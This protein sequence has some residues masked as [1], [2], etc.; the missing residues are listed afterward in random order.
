MEYNITSKTRDGVL[1]SELTLTYEH[2]GK[3]S[4]WPSGPYT[5]YVRVYVPNASKLTAARVNTNNV[6]DEDVLKKITEVFDGN[7]K[8][9]AYQLKVEPTEIVKFTLS[10]DLPES[11]NI[12]KTGS[13]Y[14]LVWQK[15]PGTTDDA[16][17]F[18]FAPP[19]GI[20]VEAVSENLSKESESY[21]RR[22]FIDSDSFYSIKFK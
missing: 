8:Y 7:Y 1:R 16:Y 19:F 15:Q 10:Y 12:S 14:S 17:T 6:F 9:F 13:S 21:V 5:N 11:L 2:T 20:N 18:N 3:D 22:G 4:S